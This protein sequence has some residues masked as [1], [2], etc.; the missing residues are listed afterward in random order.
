MA[1]AT[2]PA[3]RAY[4]GVDNAL[5]IIDFYGYDT[6][7][8]L[9]TYSWSGMT[10]SGTTP[11]DGRVVSFGTFA[12]EFSDQQGQYQGT[13]FSFTLSDYDQQFRKFATQVYQRHL[14]STEVVVKI[15]SA[16]DLKAGNV[17]IVVARGVLSKI[18]FPSGMLVRCSCEDQLTFD[19]RAL[20]PRRVVTTDFWTSHI[21]AAEPIIYGNINANG[22]PA[23]GGF[24]ELLYVGDVTVEINE[25]ITGPGNGPFTFAVFMLAGHACKSIDHIYVDG[26]R[27][28]EYANVVSVFGGGVDPD[29]IGVPGMGNWSKISATN[30]IDKTGLNGETR[31]YTLIY[32][33]ISTASGTYDYFKPSSICTDLKN[34]TKKLSV[35]VQGT[36]TVGD[37]S[38][39]LITDASDELKHFLNNYGFIDDT[40][41]SGY[42][43]GNYGTRTW[44]DGTNRVASL[45]A[46]YP[47]AGIFNAQIPVR[48]AVA[49]FI[50]VAS[51]EGAWSRKQQFFVD[52]YVVDKAPV[53]TLTE[54]NDILT[55]FRWTEDPDKMVNILPWEWGADYVGQTSSVRETGRRLTDDVSIFIAKQEKLGQLISLDFS[56]TGAV[57]GGPTDPPAAMTQYALTNTSP[58]PRYLDVP[59]SLPGLTYELGDT[60]KIQHRE[61]P[62]APSISDTKNWRLARAVRAAVDIDGLTVTLTMRD[63]EYFR[64]SLGG[65][66]TH[67]EWDADADGIVFF[68]TGV[69]VSFDWDLAATLLPGGF[70]VQMRTWGKISG[71]ALYTPQVW[72]YTAGSQAGVGSAISSTSFQANGSEQ[73]LAI[74]ATTGIKVYGLRGK[75]VSGTNAS[76]RCYGYGWLEIVPT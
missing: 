63:L 50:R 6:A 19:W 36:E 70:T 74:T 64:R 51:Y 47:A 40:L 14:T 34:G 48:D 41:P 66:R 59:L 60:F 5:A 75:T 22:G 29:I 71:T 27:H 65:S 33:C 32:C 54:T 73:V 7:G 39:T 9:K 31:R 10:V 52:R 49:K 58:A 4:Q 13:S 3:S 24:R 30:Y 62:G 25:D 69:L 37:G 46:S 43:T 55:G 44:A 12:R 18:D 11:I 17:P 61:G 21:A 67:G 76:N 23:N 68:P 38:G 16:A 1:D 8:A 28:D 35:D 20:V 26:V 15:V 53:A 72:N 2:F 56:R 45:T 42:L 57:E